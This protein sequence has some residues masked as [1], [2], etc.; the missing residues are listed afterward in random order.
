MFG[1]IGVGL[2]RGLD[3]IEALRLGMAAG[4]LNVTRRGLGTGTRV[5]ID[6][7]AAHVTV[8]S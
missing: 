5:E 3:M 8:R 7:L 4:A 1:A 2:A 6:C